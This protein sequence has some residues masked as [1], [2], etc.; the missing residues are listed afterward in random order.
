MRVL[1]LDFS[2]AFNMIVPQDHALVCL[3]RQKHIY[4][5]L[6]QQ[7]LPHGCVL[8]PLLFPLMTQDLSTM[9]RR[10]H[11]KYAA[12]TTWWVS[13]GTTANWPPERR[14]NSGLVQHK[15]L[16]LNI[17]NRDKI[18]IDTRKGPPSNTSLHLLIWS[19][20]AGSIYWGY[21]PQTP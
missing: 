11:V 13:S 16:I 15:H 8:N 14:G 10:N 2:C 12:D 19:K 6:L 1:P 7:Q 18:I 3:G 21:R 5:H 4:H 17:N 9:L 20:S